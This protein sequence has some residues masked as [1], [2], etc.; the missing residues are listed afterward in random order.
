[1]ADAIVFDVSP[2][3]H[4][5]DGRNIPGVGLEQQ[6]ELLDRRPF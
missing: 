2:R 5:I 3:T 1:V 6:Y 4:W